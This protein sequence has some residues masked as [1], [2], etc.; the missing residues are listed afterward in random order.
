MPGRPSPGSRLVSVKDLQA[1]PRRTTRRRLTHHIGPPYTRGRRP[2]RADEGVVQARVRLLTSFIA[3]R[4]SGSLG[5]W[6][7]TKP[8]G[9][10][11][12]A[13]SRSHRDL[14]VTTG[15]AGH[16]G[17]A[18]PASAQHHSSKT[19]QSWPAHTRPQHA[20]ASPDRP[21]APAHPTLTRKPPSIVRRKLA[22][23]PKR[24]SRQPLDLPSSNNES[25]ST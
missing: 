10:V 11:P 20:H 13:A 12:E 9:L 23:N 15:G 1:H 3:L 5:A 4:V 6:V 24:E 19:D 22:W 14:R 25:G 8:P 18:R 16:V 7:T 17:G 2:R 21:R